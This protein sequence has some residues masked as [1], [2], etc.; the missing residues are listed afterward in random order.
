M[1][2]QGVAGIQAAAGFGPKV[3]DMVVISHLHGDH[4][5]GLL[6]AEGGIPNAQAV[7]RSGNSA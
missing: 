2:A 5:N 7:V 1:L 3:V 6:S 4:V